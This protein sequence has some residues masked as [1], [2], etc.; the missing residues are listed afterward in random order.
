MDPCG[1][2]SFNL[3]QFEAVWWLKFL[4]LNSTLCHLSLTYDLSHSLALQ[5]IPWTSNLNSKVSWL[6]QSDALA[7]SQ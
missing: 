4:F 5:V 2:P 3:L 6:T 7:R 1:T